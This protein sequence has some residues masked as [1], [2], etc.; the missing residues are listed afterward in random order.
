MLSIDK[1]IT[2]G[3]INERKS[4]HKSIKY[5]QTISNKDNINKKIN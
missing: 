4:I 3:V 2:A 1:V 5:G